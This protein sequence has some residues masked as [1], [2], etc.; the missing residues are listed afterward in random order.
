MAV[1]PRAL[2]PSQLCRILNSTPLGE[3]ITEHALR[4]QRTRSGI[5]IAPPDAATLDIF[6]YVAWLVRE[7]RR[8][9]DTAA[10][11]QVLTT[12]YDAHRERMRERSAALSKSGRDIGD[13]PPVKNRRRRNAG[14]GSLRKFCE[15]YGFRTFNKPWSPNH[16]KSIER[17]ERAI[18]TGGLFAFAMPRGDGKTSLTE[19]AAMWALLFRHRRFVLMIGASSGLAEQL[20]GSV[21]K[22][23]ENNPLLLEDFPEVC[24][25]ISKLGGVPIRAKAQLCNGE[26]THME[27]S[28]DEVVLPTIKRS[29][30][31]GA[32]IMAKGITGAVRGTKSK[33]AMGDQIRPDFVIL[34]DPQ[35]D[36]S[37]NSVSQCRAREKVI[38]GTIL[39]LAGPG[40]KISAVM[41]CTVITPGDL[42]DTMLDRQKHPEWQGERFKMVQTMPAALETLWQEYFEI[43]RADQ[44]LGEDHGPRATAFYKRNRRAMDEGAEVAWKERY[45]K[46]YEL[47]ALQHAMNLLCDR[48]EAAFRAEYQNDPMPKVAPASGELT[49]DDV[50]GRIN[51]VPRA[52]VPIWATRLTAFIDVQEEL[53]F[54]LVCA[55][56]DDFTGAVIDYGSTPDQGKAYY[57]VRTAKRTLS[58]A[59]PKAGLEGRI[60]AGLE[61]TCKLLLDREW[62]QQ[63]DHVL[64]VERTLI[65]AN[66]GKSTD[67]VYDFCRNSRWASSVTPSHGRYIGASSTP[68]ADYQKRPGERTG[69]N[70]RMP[71]GTGKRAVRHVAFDANWWKSFIQLRLN[72]SMGD[73]TAMTVFGSER[74]AHQMLADQWTAECAVATTAKGRTVDEWKLKAP[75]LDNHWLDCVVGAAVAASMQGCRLNVSSTPPRKRA[76]IRMSEVTRR[77]YGA[78]G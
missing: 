24:F 64:R 47:S 17:L 48:K 70:W 28:S 11:T 16:L 40:E 32:V 68:M 52:L 60:F 41:P 61:A 69:A 38:A 14:G 36:E 35:T 49:P 21:Q 37:A 20:M 8:L 7:R 72:V 3:V 23:L 50:M 67:T 5:A 54:W 55:W 73:R 6:R 10:P 31:S 26:R 74:V 39:G 65:D 29:K 58:L 75:G 27:W 1:D 22:E 9:C 77:R 33:T 46:D 53:L 44:E 71:T 43:R 13:I 45:H 56:A 59:F 78:S 76:K 4:R 62:R 63:G 19:W 12:A 51:G 57:G 2:K 66:W 18:R 15:T 30:A 25:P 34:D 42:A